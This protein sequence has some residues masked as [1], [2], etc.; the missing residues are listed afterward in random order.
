M[1]EFVFG[2]NAIWTKKC[3]DDTLLEEIAT[4]ELFWM[5]ACSTVHFLLNFGCGVDRPQCAEVT[6]TDHTTC[7]A[8]I[9]GTIVKYDDDS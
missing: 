3:L 9:I 4:V 2:M 8:S 1:D 7:E 6:T 5:E